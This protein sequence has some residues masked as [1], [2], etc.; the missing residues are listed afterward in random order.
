VEHELDRPVLR[1]PSAGVDVEGA[2][3]QALA[4]TRKPQFGRNDLKLGE[5]DDPVAATLEVGGQR[6]Q[7]AG[8]AL[9][10]AVVEAADPGLGGADARDR[11][12]RKAERH[13]H[14]PGAEAAAPFSVQTSEAVIVELHEVRG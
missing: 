9:E 6:R 3:V 4:G 11:L 1:L 12:G 2:V 10:E 5:M 13:A 14:W 8:E 7:A